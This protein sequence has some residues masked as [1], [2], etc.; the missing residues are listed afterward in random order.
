MSR[1]TKAFIAFDVI[2]MILML[3]YFIGLGSGPTVSLWRDS[4][5]IPK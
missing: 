2:I 5:S 1:G 4:R 3:M